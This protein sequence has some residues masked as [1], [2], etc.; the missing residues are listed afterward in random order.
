[1]TVNQYLPPAYIETVW[2]LAAGI[3]PVSAL[4]GACRVPGLVRSI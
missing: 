4:G 2:R 3:D 1:M